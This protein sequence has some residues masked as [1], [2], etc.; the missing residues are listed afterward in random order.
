M[1]NTVI[2]VTDLG[3]FKAYRL[4][5]DGLHSSPRLELI[6]NFNTVTAHGKLGDK[7][8]DQAGQFP[9][10]QGMPG[11]TGDMSNGERH[12]IEL[13]QRKRLIKQLAER[14]NTVV[15]D[16]KVERCFFAAGREYNQQ[17]VD[18]LAPRARAKIEKNVPH[19][20]TKIDK[21]ELL[22]HF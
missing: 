2:V 6:E 7:L 11:T 13:E 16:E 8:T 19:N 21:S 12:N 10:G 9:K 5:Q 3:S 20:L 18:E 15:G 22:K 4:D 14:F 1:K 17:I